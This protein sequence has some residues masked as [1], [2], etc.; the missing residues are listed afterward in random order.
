M[1]APACW[2]LIR[3]YLN[4]CCAD[5]KVHNMGD[6]E[7][8]QSLLGLE[9]ALRQYKVRIGDPETVQLVGDLVT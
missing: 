4:K 3:S 5:L 7:T 6:P 9:G 1:A 8:V 2:S